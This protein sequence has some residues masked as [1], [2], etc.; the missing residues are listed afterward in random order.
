MKKDLG[1][2]LGGFSK[3]FLL[4]IKA[5]QVQASRVEWVSI[6]SVGYL[7][8]IIVHSETDELLAQSSHAFSL[9]I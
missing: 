1:F 4:H 8:L 9:F 2:P 6:P 3:S 5:V 7:S